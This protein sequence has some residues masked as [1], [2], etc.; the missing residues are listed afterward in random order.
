MASPNAHT[1]LL[2]LVPYEAMTD[3][4]MKSR[5]PVPA[6]L[7]QRRAASLPCQLLSL[8]AGQPAFANLES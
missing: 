5:Q 7:P 3:G 2:E 6:K 1:P 4:V 8:C